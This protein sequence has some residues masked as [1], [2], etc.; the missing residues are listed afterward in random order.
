MSHRPST[1]SLNPLSAII[2]SVGN[3]VSLTQPDVMA[4]EGM[5]HAAKDSDA[6]YQG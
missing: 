5:R 4:G 2:G 1:L 3:L 6:D